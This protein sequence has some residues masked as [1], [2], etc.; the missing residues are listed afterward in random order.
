MR[1]WREQSLGTVFGLLFLLCLLG[2]AV[3]GLADYNEQQATLGL[4]GISLL[5]YVTSSSFAVDV[6]ENWQSEYLQFLL[7]IVGTV[8][9]VQRGSPE[10]KEVD[11]AG[12]D[13]DED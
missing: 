4:P 5:R 7:Y 8:W 2:Q 9:L 1:K 10:S 12:L 3:T 11:R 6:A 13:S